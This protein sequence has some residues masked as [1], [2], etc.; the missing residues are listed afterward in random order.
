MD[1]LFQ[2]NGK[3]WKIPWKSKKFLKIKMKTWISFL[4]FRIIQVKKSSAGEKSD[5]LKMSVSSA[6]DSHF[7]VFMR[8]VKHMWFYEKMIA[9][10]LSLGALRASLLR[11]AGPSKKW[12][13]ISNVTF[14][15]HIFSCLLI[16]LIN[17]Y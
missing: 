7:G 10:L 13:E 17:M 3:T 12:T 9:G 16:N 6:R 15:S 4:N 14:P 11:W 1:I 5:F 8:A 2:I